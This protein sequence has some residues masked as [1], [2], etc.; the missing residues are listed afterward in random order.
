[1]KKALI[2]LTSLVIFGTA[3]TAC[4][5]DKKENT[6]NLDDTTLTPT[7][8]MSEK[9]SEEMTDISEDV[10]KAATDASEKMSEAATDV[11]DAINGETTTK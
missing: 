6:T 7:T 10:S 5:A 3:F 2:I 4:S 9:V 1:M 8:S 11:S